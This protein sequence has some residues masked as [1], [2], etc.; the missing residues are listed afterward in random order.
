M[1]GQVTKLLMQPAFAREIPLPPAVKSTEE[2]KAKQTLQKNSTLNDG[3]IWKF[4][5]ALQR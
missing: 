1:L 5:K 4:Y 3:H 2:I